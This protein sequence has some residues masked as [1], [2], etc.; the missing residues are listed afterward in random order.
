MTRRLAVRGRVQGV[1]YRESMRR[2][3]ER[4]GVTG[5]V[6]NRGDGSVEAVVQ[7]S[8]EAVEAITRWA[9]RGPEDARVTG[10]EVSDAE[11]DFFRFETRASF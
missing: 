4:L 1:F 7:G 10:V 6:C 5:W 3:A 9:R 2:E 11:G 8:P